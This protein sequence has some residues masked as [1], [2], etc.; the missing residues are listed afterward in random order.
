LRRIAQHVGRR[1]TNY[2]EALRP[3]PGI[4]S[5]VSLRVVAHVVGKP[6]YLDHQS[7]ARAVEVDHQVADRMMIAELH[8][9]RSLAQV[10][11]Q[12]ALG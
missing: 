3:Q 12:Q 10:V 5:A 4:P 9:M 1:N 8:A 6:I 2:L 11:P 7:P